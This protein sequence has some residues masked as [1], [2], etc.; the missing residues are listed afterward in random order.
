MP[1]NRKKE[2]IGLPARWRLVHG[3]YYFQVPPGLEDLW[4]GKKMF[5][6][7]KTMPE[8]YREWAKRLDSNDKAK[9]ALINYAHEAN[10]DQIFLNC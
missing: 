9:E 6:L 8:A 1:K 7:G 5:R 4:D 2:N 3:A 10:A